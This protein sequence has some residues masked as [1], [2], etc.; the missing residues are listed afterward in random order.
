MRNESPWFKSLKG[1]SDHVQSFAQIDHS[2]G[3]GIGESRSGSAR[4]RWDARHRCRELGSSHSTS[5]LLGTAVRGDDSTVLGARAKLSAAAK[6]LQFTD[7]AARHAELAVRLAG[8]SQLL[9][10]E[11][12]SNDGG[13]QRNQHRL[14]RTIQ[15]GAD[16][17]SNQRD[18]KLSGCRRPLTPGA[19]V[20]A[21]IAPGGG[22][23]KHAIAAKPS[24]RQ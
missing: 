4:E 18:P 2:S 22:Y 8:E 17:H 23:L 12:L 20:R 5:A 3:V 11:L 9:A 24:Q 14:P 15:S 21:P 6:H 7:R 10:G 16:E 1:V 19:A 13:H